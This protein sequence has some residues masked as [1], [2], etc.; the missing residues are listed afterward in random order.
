MGLKNR[1]FLFFLILMVLLSVS[2]VCATE[3]TTVEQTD[4]LEP[5]S[6]VETPTD[7]SPIDQS[8]EI[9]ELDDDIS[10]EQGVATNGNVNGQNQ[11]NILG[12]TNAEETP[13]KAATTLHMDGSTYVWL[14]IRS[15][16]KGYRLS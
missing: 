16:S 4:E 5:L 10:S 2:V 7:Q 8:P 14:Y 15:N 3:N 12:A 11:K 9:N 13:L 1:L 6:A